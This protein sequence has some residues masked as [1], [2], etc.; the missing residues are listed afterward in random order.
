MKTPAFSI[1]IPAKDRPK[2]LADAIESVLLQDFRDVEIVISNNGA[3]R[4]V[5]EVVSKYL[6][7]DR[8]RYVEQP[9][10]LSMPA[11]WDKVTKELVGEYILFLTDRSVL[12]AGTLSFLC[13]QIEIAD[14]LPDVITWPWD[15]YYDNL[16][17]LLRYPATDKKMQLLNSDFQLMNYAPGSS[18]SYYLLP[19]ALNSCVRNEFIDAIRA[20]YGR[21]FRPLNLDFSFG[22]LCL[23]QKE[24][25]NYI[26]YPLFVS[27]GLKVSNGGNGFDGDASPFIDSL[28]LLDPFEHVPVKLPLVQNS[29]HQDFLAMATLCGRDDLLKAWN[30]TNY[31]LDCFL[32]VDAKRKA[33]VLS[34]N[35]VDNM[36]RVLANT[37]TRESQETQLAVNKTRT[38]TKKIR[39]QVIRIVRKLLSSRLEIVR[40]FMLLRKKEGVVYATALEAAGFSPEDAK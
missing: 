7:D 4:A 13:K 14:T 11:H 35:H 29:I 33:G 32:E 17:V 40:K 38:L 8:V 12:R 31:Y 37:L 9:E 3:D 36:E 34:V 22:Y 27:Q 6:A 15:I 10:L 5:R 19:R 24:S 30:R 2:Y 20:K 16:K 21:V 39:T 23:L 1:F 28:G 26:D 25:F 18:Q